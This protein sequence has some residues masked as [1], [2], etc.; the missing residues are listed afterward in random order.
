[1]IKRILFFSL[2]VSLMLAACV[3]PVAKQP[4]TETEQ[5]LNLTV[6]RSPT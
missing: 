6:Y 3:A 2:F 5:S 4:A 1:M